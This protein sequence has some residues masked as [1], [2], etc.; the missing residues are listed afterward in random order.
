MLKNSTF[1]IS[2]SNDLSLKLFE[3]LKKKNIW[4]KIERKNY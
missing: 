4:K 2:T 3:I 1:L